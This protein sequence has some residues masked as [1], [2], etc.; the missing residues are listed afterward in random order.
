MKRDE[1]VC[2]CSDLDEIIAITGEGKCVVSRIAE[3]TYMGKDIRHIAVFEKNDEKTIYNM[4]YEDG[5]KGAIMVKRFFVSGVTRDKVYDLTKGKEGS[6]VL[7]LSV[8][9]VDNA[10]R[11]NVTL[12]PRPKLKN[13]NLEVKFSEVLVKNRSAI[14]VVLTKFPIAKIRPAEMGAAAE[15]KNAPAAPQ[16][17]GKSQTKLDL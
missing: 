5:P 9:G 15:Q 12:K 8:S 4:I 10:P 16:K 6:R 3:K 7:Y 1:F 13:L 14:G 17:S 2:D 11:V